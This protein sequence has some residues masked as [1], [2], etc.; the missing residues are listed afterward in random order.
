MRDHHI[1]LTNL[2]TDT[3]RYVLVHPS[4]KGWHAEMRTLMAD[5][6]WHRAWY[7][8]TYPNQAGARNAI[9]VFLGK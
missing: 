8:E 1:F 9:K 6:S 7:S 5:G 2:D 3:E 4:R